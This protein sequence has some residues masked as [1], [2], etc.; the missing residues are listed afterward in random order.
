V[1]AGKMPQTSRHVTAVSGSTLLFS[2]SLSPLPG[3]GS[4]SPGN[5]KIAASGTAVT[6]R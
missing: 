3:N 5:G 6:M 2:M 4:S 1:T